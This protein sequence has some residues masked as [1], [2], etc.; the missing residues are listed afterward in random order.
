MSTPNRRRPGTRDAPGTGEARVMEPT[1]RAARFVP[2]TDPDG[3]NW[4]PVSPRK[5]SSPPAESTTAHRESLPAGAVISVG[6]PVSSN[7][8]RRSSRDARRGQ[9]A[10]RESLPVS[11]VISVGKPE[12]SNPPRRASRDAR[13]GQLANRKSL[14]VKS[15]S[16]RIRTHHSL[17][18]PTAE[19][20]TPFPPE[21]ARTWATARGRGPPG[22]SL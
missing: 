11:A 7:P 14:P 18:E 13:R 10:N 9:L 19:D 5:S 3:E 21:K 2:V 16:P 4:I 20:A 15:S 6:K 12:P 22:A 8:P 1:G 17:L